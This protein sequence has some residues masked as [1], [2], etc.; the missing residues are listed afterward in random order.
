MMRPLPRAASIVAVVVLGT[1]VVVAIVGV[2]VWM[3]RERPGARSLEDALREFRN[4]NAGAI[5]SIGAVVGRPPVGV[6][7]ASG[8]GRASIDFPPASQSYG[9]TIPV[10]VRHQ[11]DDCWS[12]QVDFNSAYSQTWDYCA[13]DGA[14]SE[15]AN[16]TSTRWDF[17]FTTIDEHTDFVCDPPGSIVRAGERRDAVS[18]YSCA[19]RN[20]S[21][22]GST[23]SSVEFTMVGAES[24][25]IGGA[26][27]P[28]FHYR[29]VDRLSG[30]QRGTT[31]IDYWYAVD[32]FL[33]VRM[34]RTNELHTDSPIGS[35]TYSETGSL[36]LQSLEPAR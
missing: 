4:G 12:T 22:G 29:E 7:L 3:G 28:T 33:L 31:T 11:G 19:G 27:T 15:L 24:I 34:T 16:H 14:V 26:P 6:Y 10:T 36:Q 20:S 35:I 5:E 32:S 25:D 1:V 8:A 18:S 2:S 13:T 21:V 30:A 23:T 9:A 17:G